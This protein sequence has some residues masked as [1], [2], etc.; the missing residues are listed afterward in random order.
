MWHIPEVRTVAVLCVVAVV[1]GLNG[2]T[3]TQ[4][5]TK[6]AT[7]TTERCVQRSS[8][9]LDVGSDPRQFAHRRR[10]LKPGL[11]PAAHSPIGTWCLGFGTSREAGILPC[12]AP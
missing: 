3:L 9:A 4:W 1:I 12:H 7:G 5:R 2:Y 11:S 10:S 8:T 6:V